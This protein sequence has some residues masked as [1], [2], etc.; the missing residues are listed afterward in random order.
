[1]KKWALLLALLAGGCSSS[2]APHAFR[3]EP[4]PDTFGSI[5]KVVWPGSTAKPIE[6]GYERPTSLRSPDG[7]FLAV[8]GD[9]ALMIVDLV[10]RRADA[11]RLGSSCAEVPILW[12]R[13]DRLVFRLWCGDVHS[14]A[15]SELL[16]FD[17][18]RKRFVGRREIGSGASKRT[19]YGAV[20]L[21]D[22]PLGRR[23]AG[24][25][26]EEFL[27]PARL[28]R[29]HTHGRVDEVRLPIRAG[30]AR[31][32][33]INRWPAFV[34]DPPGRYAYVIGEGD[35]CARVDLRTLRVEWHRLPHAFDAQPQLASKPRQHTGTIP[36]SRDV[37][38]EAVWRGGGKIAVTGDDTWTSNDFDRTAPA[39]LKIL[40]IRTWTVR[41]VDPRVFTLALDCSRWT[42]P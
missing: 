30:S 6:I 16:V 18:V 28:L 42:R 38:R 20:L 7:R 10:H 4:R 27:G 8:A 26:R 39:G 31:F 15:R 5:Y 11:L 29:V 3:V 34:V 21:T 23:L 40:D 24:G 12:R 25:V 2:G 22:P 37:R 19:R 36:P 41:L 32:R 14:S 17:P 1:V 13:Q 35:G 33:A 9:E